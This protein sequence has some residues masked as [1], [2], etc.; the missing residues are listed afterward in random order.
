MILFSAVIGCALSEPTDVELMVYTD[1]PSHTVS[2]MLYGLFFEDINFAADG[3][4]YAELIQNRSFE[5]KDGLFNWTQ[6]KRNGGTADIKIHN[7]SPLNPDNPHYLRLSIQGEA[8]QAGVDNSGYGGIAVQKGKRYLFSLYARSLEGFE[9]GLAIRLEGKNGSSLGQSSIGRIR[10]S[11]WTQYSGTLEARG[12]DTQARLAVVARGKGTID[13]DMVS[14]FPEDTWKRQTNGLRADLVE[15]LK[16]LKPAFIRFPGGCIVEG[17]N[18]ANAYRWKDTIG[19]PAQR[20]MN[21][22]RWAGWNSPPE[23]YQSYGLGF[24]EFFR[25]CEDLGAE[26][27]PILNCG[28]SCQYQDAQLVPLDQ[29]DPYVQDALDLIE[30]ANGP[31]SSPWGAKRAEAGHPAPF[32]LKYLGVGNEQWGEGYF[33]R[34]DIF[35]KAIKAKYPDIQ[36]VTTSG[37]GSDG[38][39]YDLAWNK[40]K[41]GTP[42][43]IVD[44]HYYRPPQ[45]FLQNDN[46]YDAFDRNGPKIFAGEYAAHGGGRRNTLFAALTEAAFITGLERNSDVVVMASYAPLLAKIGSTQ[47]TPDLVFFDNTRVFGT[48]SYYVQKM[49]SEHATGVYLKNELKDIGRPEP[50]PEGRIGLCTWETTAEFKDIKVSRANQ[51]LLSVLKIPDWRVVEGQWVFKGQSCTQSDERIQGA[52]CYAGELGWGNYTLSLK[53]RKTGGR[54]GFIVAFRRDQNDDGLQW[55]LGGW[56]NAKHAIQ[57]VE[58]NATNILIEAPG[59]IET[60]RWYDIRIELSGERVQCFLDG[61]LIHDINIPVLSTK[62]VY[63]SCTRDEAAKVLYIKAVNPTAEALSLNVRLEGVQGVEPTASVLILTGNG[64]DAENSLHQPENVYPM[65]VTADVIDTR[66]NYVLKPYSLNILR[67]KER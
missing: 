2:P 50:K 58:G 29:L 36:I 41:N 20:R 37:P 33:E 12:D 56:G 66:F 35:Y 38:R 51:T 30:Y 48:P 59:S 52:I 49:F 8:G 19:D 18:L 11:E 64:P 61:K 32:H 65:T 23:Y 44:E 60:D 28:M 14:L 17:K 62:R 1:R 27:L 43:E 63:A 39:W 24:F 6:V 67:I 9:G 22:N 46:R 7:E 21:W 10:S 3:G 25:L 40:F 4:L 53:A 34:Y 13:I 26:P 57:A 54:E 55:N 45:W 42:A 15:T 47:W 5:F 16:D 31:A